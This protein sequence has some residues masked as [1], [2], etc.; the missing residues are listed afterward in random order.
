[1]SLIFVGNALGYIV[2]APFVD[3]IRRRLG[4]AKTLALCDSCMVLGF[5]P[6][7]C[8]APFPAIV[9]GYF[10]IGFGFAFGLAI[11]NVCASQ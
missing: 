3:A 5:I 1:M 2:A 7:L 11:G 9:A 8:A 10:F 6:F 4:R